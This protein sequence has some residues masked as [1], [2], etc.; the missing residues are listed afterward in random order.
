MKQNDDD[1]PRLTVGAGVAQREGPPSCLDASG[2]TGRDNPRSRRV[3][4]ANASEARRGLFAPVPDAPATPPLPV[5]GG[6]SEGR[7]PFY[8]LAAVIAFVLRSIPTMTFC[9]L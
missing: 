3:A 7:G 6:G 9:A 8:E 4:A 1:D 5:H 2:A